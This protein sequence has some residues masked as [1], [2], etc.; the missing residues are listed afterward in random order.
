MK[1][2]IQR[3]DELRASDIM[4][5]PAVA[6]RP[7]AF[8]EEV[9]ELLADREISGMPVVNGDGEVV[10]VISERDLAHALGGPLIRLV[11]RRPVHTGPFLR[12]PVACE[13]SRVQDIMTRPAMLAH[14]DTPVRTLAEIMVKEQV[15]RIP[16]VRANRLIGV[17]TRGDVLAAVADLAHG[18]VKLGQPPVIVGSGLQDARFDTN[19]YRR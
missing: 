10:G 19:D 5:T 6:C 2:V 1:D 12:S 13:G 16:I 18:G 3:T 4:S 7:E 9:A 17:V 8:C 11:L 15:N 14:P